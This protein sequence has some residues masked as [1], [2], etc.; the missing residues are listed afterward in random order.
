MQK[1][2][3]KRKTKQPGTRKQ[4]TANDVWNERQKTHTILFST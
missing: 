4:L 1:K 3:N 2:V